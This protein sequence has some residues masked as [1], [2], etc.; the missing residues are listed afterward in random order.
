MYKGVYAYAWDLVD[1][2]FD[3]ALGRMRECGINTVTLAASYHAG[4]FLR[5]HAPNGKVYFPQ[6]GTVYFRPRMERYGAIKP[7]PN[8]LLDGHDPFA[9]LRQA[10]PDLKRVAW[11]VCLHNTELGRRHPEFTVRNAYGD[12]YDYSLCPACDAVRDYVV[13]L[14]AD[15]AE[16]YELDGIALETPGFLPFDH[17]FHHEFGLVPL[18]RW[19]KWLLA[20]CFSDATVEKARDHGLDVE[21]LRRA[22]RATLDRF[23]VEPR[24]VPD[25]I[26]FEWLIADLVADP[27][28][29]A[30]L[31]WR[32]SVVTALVADVRAA[33]PKETTLAVIP[34]VQRP[35]AACW[36]EGSD[37]KGLAAAAD[38]LEVPAYEPSAAAARLDA[39]D[40]RRRAGD[41]A[42]L[43]FILRPAH[44]DLADGAE[45]AAAAL[46][47]R[48]VGMA[49]IAFYNYGHFALDAMDRIREALAALDKAGG[50]E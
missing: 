25:S 37:L 13:T 30:F 3:T 39:E 48:E 47:L 45:T 42:T 4:K 10:A 44:P 31:N 43:H 18:N 17:G 27:E 6:D 7:V 29:S 32:C 46:A 9:E 34:T 16:R 38:I 5:P 12:A 24:A 28:W 19:V 21:R 26:A 49:G 11:T 50:P 20:L 8:A 2:G 23:F 33:L 40:V 14:C 22:T 36:L 35:T 41:D 1:E 15:M